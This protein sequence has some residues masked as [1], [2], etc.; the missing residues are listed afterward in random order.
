M[1]VLEPL[2]ASVRNGHA[3]AEAGRAELLAGEKAVEHLCAGNAVLIL[4]KQRCLFEDALLAARVEIEND[5]CDCPAATAID[6]TRT[7][8]LPSV[9]VPA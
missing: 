8:S 3:L 6:A 2:D 7:K 9:A 4:E 5:A 1:C